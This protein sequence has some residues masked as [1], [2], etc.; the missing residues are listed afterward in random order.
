MCISSGMICPSTDPLAAAIIEAM[1]SPKGSQQ[2]ISFSRAAALDATTC[3]DGHLDG[4]LLRRPRTC[5]TIWDVSWGASFH[6]S[7][8]PIRRGTIA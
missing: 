6:E 1:N 3:K 2:P 4:T 7:R 8:G 5:S